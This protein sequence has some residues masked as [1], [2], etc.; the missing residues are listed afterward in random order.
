MNGMKWN[1]VDNFC[2]TKIKKFLRLVVLLFICKNNFFLPMFQ[3]LS[4]NAFRWSQVF[5]GHTTL[6]LDNGSGYL[7]A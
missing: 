4:M 3:F 1:I 5:F 2:L 7:T 6:V